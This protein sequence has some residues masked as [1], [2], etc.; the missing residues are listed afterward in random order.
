MRKDFILKSYETASIKKKKEI[1]K[2]FYWVFPIDKKD[3]IENDW[4]KCDNLVNGCL[5]FNGIGQY[6]KKVK[7]KHYGL[8]KD[9]PGVY[10]KQVD[11]Q[12]W[13]V[14]GEFTPLKRDKWN[15]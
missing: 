4:Y 15:I 9:T 2:Y 13:R 8:L 5:G 14:N 1:K 7:I 12:I 11:E 10:L 3:L 6:I